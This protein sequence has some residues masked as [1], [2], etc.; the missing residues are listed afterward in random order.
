[1]GGDGGQ[2][3]QGP[4]IEPFSATSCPA[5]VGRALVT[6]ATLGIVLT[7]LRSSWNSDP[8]AAMEPISNITKRLLV[9][10]KREMGLLM[11][12]FGTFAA[13]K[14]IVRDVRDKDDFVNGVVAGGLA[15]S[16]GALMGGVNNVSRLVGIAGAFAFAGGLAT[17]AH[18]FSP[19]SSQ[20]LAVRK[21][22]EQLLANAPAPT[23][24]SK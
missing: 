22:N 4:S 24:E 10:S 14:C 23:F 1:M 7:G 11:T 5:D 12:V 20:A 15:G 16:C 2:H 8:A 17:S 9:T 3:G 6:G 19:S 21:R 13:T 18:K